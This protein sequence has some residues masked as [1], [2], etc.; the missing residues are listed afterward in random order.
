MATSERDRLEMMSGLK[1]LQLSMASRTR[2]SDDSFTR[3]GVFS[4]KTRNAR[5]DRDFLTHLIGFPS[6]P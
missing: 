3:A 1:T 4:S 5:A 2:P 6:M